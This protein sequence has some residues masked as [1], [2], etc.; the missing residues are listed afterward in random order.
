MKQAIITGANGFIGRNLVQELLRRNME[1]ICIDASLSDE[2]MNNTNIGFVSCIE[3]SMD[4]MYEHLNGKH[5]DAFFHFGWAG[6]SGNARGDYCL[7]LDNVKQTCDY[8]VLSKKLG[9][10]RFIFASS[11][12]EMQT[13]EYLQMD[14]ISPS[15]GYIYGAAKL[16]GHL[17][18]E[19]V[20]YQNGIEF[21]PVI[22]SNIYGAGEK[23]A[24]LINTTVR[25]L[26]NHE[27]CS[28]TDGHQMYD[29]IYVTDA[30]NA[31]TEIS[32]KGKAYHRYYIGSG[33]I[34]PLADYLIELKDIV[35]PH[36]IL[37]LGE[38][39]FNETE[40]DYS[41]FDLMKVQE[42]TGYINKISFREGIKLIINDI[43][44]GMKN[45]KI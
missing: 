34:R 24:R 37:G 10:K 44:E 26:L 23:S 39:P 33:D 21:I 8:I 27:H 32:E 1:V 18:G 41:Q 19:T 25:K 38:L 11:I 20:A 6:T 15:S 5:Y 2:L 29:F 45:E 13:Y 30:V 36:E 12:N 22:I 16:V 42:D 17:I 4:E 35:D 3:T 40:L 14:D 7:Q 28:F 31:I 43:K 9:C